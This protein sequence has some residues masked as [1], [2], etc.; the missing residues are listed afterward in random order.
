M[1][2]PDEQKILKDLAEDLNKKSIEE[3]IYINFNPEHY[4]NEYTKDSRNMNEALLNEVKNL[5][6]QYEAKKSQYEN[7]KNNIEKC[8]NQYEEKEKE[9]KNL[10]GQKQNLES[11]VTVEKLIEEMKNYIEENYQK[12]RQRVI[13]DFMTKKIDFET[14]K[15]QFKDLTMKYHYY[16]IIKDKLNL[17]K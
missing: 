3:L 9:L 7:I 1:N 4:V 16:S 15:E 10:Y 14:F 2:S 5:N 6:N 11:Q 13:Q 17:C 8:K 12:P